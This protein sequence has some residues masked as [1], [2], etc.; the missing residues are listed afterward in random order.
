[1]DE[2]TMN[3]MAKQDEKLFNTANALFVGMLIGVPLAYLVIRWDPLPYA[4]GYNWTNVTG[5]LIIITVMMGHV[6]LI[7]K[8]ATEE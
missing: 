2:E 3:N 1:M 4:Y 8:V 5:M 7:E 6:Y